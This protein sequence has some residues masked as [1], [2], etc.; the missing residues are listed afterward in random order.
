MRLREERKSRCETFDGRAACDKA[1]SAFAALAFFKIR[2]ALVK[3]LIAMLKVFQLLFILLKLLAEIFFCRL[4]ALGHGMCLLACRWEI[5]AQRR[6]RARPLGRNRR[7]RS[8]PADTS[9]VWMSS[10]GRTN[11]RKESIEVRPSSLRDA[12]S[13]DLRKLYNA[14]GGLS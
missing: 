1:V 2:D 3:T 11:T 4:F 9:A 8:H 7:V 14:Q 13:V 5:G 6:K 12:E 10:A